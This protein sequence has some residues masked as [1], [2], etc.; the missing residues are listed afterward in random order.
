M[1]ERTDARALNFDEMSELLTEGGYDLITE[2]DGQY[3]DTDHV[4]FCE[5]CKEPMP[6]YGNADDYDIE[7]PLCDGCIEVCRENIQAE[8]E[9][10]DFCRYWSRP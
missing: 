4:Y 6:Q 9:V 7:G 10:R 2:I 8:R 5:I 3:Y 1:Y